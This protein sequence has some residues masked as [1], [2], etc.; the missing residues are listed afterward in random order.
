MSELKL[1]FLGPPQITHPKTGDI[2]LPNRKSLALLAYLS[3]ESDR[4]HR[5]ESLQALLWP[6]FSTSAA[7]NNLRVVWS[8]LHKCLNLASHDQNPYLVSTRLAVQFN[9][10]S[11]HWLDVMAFERLLEDCQSHEHDQQQTCSEC[12]A[13][14]EQAAELVR[15]EF[16]G[17]FTLGDCPAFDEW[18]LIRRERLHRQITQV[19][20]NLANYHHLAGNLQS[21]EGY[22]RRLLELNPLQ[23]SAHRQLMRLLSEM[24]QRSAA[25]AQFD[26]CRHILAN[27][28]GVAPALETTALA[29]Q[30]RSRATSR[31]SDRQHN[32]PVST[33]RFFGRQSEID[34]LKTLLSHPAHRLV[35]LT[36]P[37]GVG[38][39]RLAVQTAYGLADHFPDGVWWVE[40]S[41]LDDPQAVPSAV[42]RALKVMEQT[43]Q[44]I[45]QTLGDDLQDKCLLLV[46][47]NCEH[48]LEACAQLVKAL[49]AAA[50]R[51]LVLATSRA[52]LRLE[53]EQVMRLQPFALPDS[54]Q[55]LKAAAALEYEAVQLFVDKAAKVQLNFA[56]TDS[57]AQI[58][59]QICQNLDGMPLAIEL[60]A[61]R[62][63]VVPVEAIARRV[64]QRFRW[65]N[66][67]SSGSIPRQR[68]LVTMIDWSH[69]LLN[70][71]ERTLFRRLSVFTG[72]WT[73]EAA[74]AICSAGELCQDVLTQL[75]DQSLV[76]F[77]YDPQGRRYRM[78][79][80]IRQYARQQLRSSGED[81]N[82]FERHAHYYTE[83]VT[84][85]A[86]NIA[87]YPLKVQLD[88][89]ET[90]HD[91]LRSA[92]NWAVAQDPDL[93]LSLVTKLG[94][95]LNFWELRG[96]YEEGRRWL[97]RILDTT[98]DFVSAARAN[99]LLAAAGLSSAINDFEYGLCCAAESQYIFSQVGDLAGEVEARLVA[100]DL[101]NLQGDQIEP[102]VMAQEAMETAHQINHQAGLA[103]GGWILG[104]IAYDLGKY[105]QAIQYLLPSITIWRE[106][107]KPYQLSG[108]LNT[109]AAC[110]M[111]KGEFGA[112]SEILQ[113]TAEINQNLGYR[114]GV[115]LA[116]HNMAEA[117]TQLGDFAQARKL[118][119]ES[120]QIRRE[121][122][123]LRGYAFS[124]ENFAIL[125]AREQQAE[126]AIQLFAASQA[127]REAIGA[128]ID[129][130]TQESYANVLNELCDQVGEV[131]FELEWSKGSS[132]STDQ[133]LE[134]ALNLPQY[135]NSTDL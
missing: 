129:P 8:Q 15:G 58:V 11:N 105:D 131:L 116:L 38:K 54:A 29:E 1:A 133:A 135:G 134:F 91:N 70:E 10:D 102:G 67:Q 127:L 66:T 53:G 96:H 9:P 62:A 123:L 110:L 31:P 124:L 103:K 2:T 42:A 19:L 6:E 111:E 60:A 39:T 117:A 26:T 93:A 44:A 112:A 130:T 94:V 74:E 32:L 115:A 59:T 86:K 119:S 33:S 69:D 5:R 114:R 89:I 113:E 98:D 24:G 43:D 65:L 16:L 52:P 50:P 72:G 100:A 101:A 51:L 87:G 85:A 104:G 90:E 84:E 35:T 121:L 99:A 37:G 80:T 14:L 13:R 49:Q 63:S 68:T 57:N 41:T 125:A 78:H 79:E 28:L 36:G 55:V 48:L 17:G 77:G 92:F 118:N 64:D 18:T 27:E 81:T 95:D 46:M 132:M 108:T 107:A 61:A 76:V 122:K 21:A 126:R 25:L 45:V 97:R 82:V 47:D 106:L 30:I 75:V 7:Q 71:A 34:A 12:A 23:E 73:L 120:L 83:L 4:P 3:I 22:V 20:G 128:P 56:L 40:L 109:L 88:A